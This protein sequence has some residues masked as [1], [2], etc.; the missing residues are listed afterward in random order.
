M[1]PAGAASVIDAVRSSTPGAGHFA[2]TT[3]D[4]VYL[5]LCPRCGDHTTLIVTR[6]RRGRVG[7]LRCPGCCHVRVDAVGA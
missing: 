1:I 7:M 5:V 3:T 4:S 2:A 6:V